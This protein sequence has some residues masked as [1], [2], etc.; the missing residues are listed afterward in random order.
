M[1]I[2]IY[3]SVTGAANRPDTRGPSRTRSIKRRRTVTGDAPDRTARV[4]HRR[5][6]VHRCARSRRPKMTLDETS[7]ARL[8]RLPVTRRNAAEKRKAPFEQKIKNSLIFSRHNDFLFRIQ[9]KN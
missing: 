9:I 7:R 3:I 5:V 8:Q 4:V 6:K 1:N 2:Y